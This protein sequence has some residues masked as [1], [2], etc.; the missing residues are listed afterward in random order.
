MTFIREHYK[1][2]SDWKGKIYLGL[3]I[4]WDYDKS[5]VNCRCWGMW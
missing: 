4:D 2:L 1:I 5:K 3:D